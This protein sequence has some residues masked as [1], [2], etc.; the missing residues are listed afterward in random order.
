MNFSNH[1]NWCKTV[2]TCSI[3]N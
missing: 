1:C 3:K 2:T